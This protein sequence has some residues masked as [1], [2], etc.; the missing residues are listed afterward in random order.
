MTTQHQIAKERKRIPAMDYELLRR[1]GLKHIEDLAHDLWTDYNTH[2]PGITLLEALCY[3]ITELGYRTQFDMKS[4]LAGQQNQ[5]LYTPKEILTVNPVTISDYR[6]LLLD[7]PGVNNAWLRK[8]ERQEIPFYANLAADTLQY[9]PTD[10]EIKLGGL[11]D[12]WLD[13]EN[14]LEYGDLNNGDILIGNPKFRFS[15]LDEVFPETFLLKIELPGLQ[16]TEHP[17]LLWEAPTASTRIAETDGRKRYELELAAHGQT[18]IIPFQVSIP[19]H[20]SIG[21]ITDEHIEVMLSKT[22]FAGQLAEQYMAKLKRAKAILLEAERRLHAHRNL[23]EDFLSVKHI[24]SEEIAFCFDVDAAADA[25]IEQVQAAVFFAIENYLNPPVRFYA[26]REM[27]DQGVSVDE[28]F[29]GVVLSHGFVNTAQLASAQLRETVRSSDIINLLMDIPGVLGI[30]NFV[31]TKYDKQGKPI[32]GSI[33]VRWN[34]QVSSGHKPVI[35]PHA[36]KVLFFKNGIPLLAR[37]DELQDSIRLLRIGRANDKLGSTQGDLPIPQAGARDTLSYWPVQYDLPITYGV[38]KYGLPVHAD[39]KRRGQQKQLRG[40]LLFFEQLL[41]DFFAQ[42]THAP[43]LFS[44]KPITRTYFAQYLEQIEGVSEVLSGELKSIIEDSDTGGSNGW[45]N[46]YEKQADFEKRRNR[47]LDH[48]LARFGESFNEY[49]LLQYRINYEA[50]TEERIESSELIQAKINTLNYYP[51]ISANRARAFNY[52]PRSASLDLDPLALWDTENVAGLKKRTSFLTGIENVT[53]R[54][55]HSIKHV[56]IICEETRVGENILCQHYFE[57][58]T[59]SGTQ[60]RSPATTRK[61]DAEA[62]LVYVLELGADPDNFRLVDQHIRL[63]GE[64]DVLLESVASYDTAE[65]ASPAI[66]E[67]ASELALPAD[68]PVGFHLL[69]HILLRPRDDAFGLME[70]CLT[71][72]ECR[73]DEDP[74]SFRVSVVLPYWPGHFDNM[75][76]RAY[77]EQKIREEAPAHVM[78]KVCW[79]DNNQM[80]TFELAYR[81]WLEALAA[82]HG[83]A[84]QNAAALQTANDALLAILAKLNNKYPKASLHDC[85]ESA[86]DSNVV[87]LGKTVLGTFTSN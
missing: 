29:D 16:D 6:K 52:F 83:N 38:S 43:D 39:D 24:D 80:R 10:L 50:R 35:A 40:Y 34:M 4:F 1:E 81:A 7:I 48:L 45:K 61:S 54:Y 22:G 44:S 75:A 12:V 15:P 73:C 87:T 19:K 74:Y 9:H 64:G 58:T 26:L 84:T 23:C 5:V 69:E 57:L 11:Y 56:E 47:F 66:S 49:A 27:L 68:D 17:W 65:A 25:D 51:D 67:L 30:R 70:V 8:S 32:V 78:V 53:R 85:E 31:M 42:L 60:Y 86:L 46:L 28:I 59:R 63:E 79:I 76:F 71:A 62:Y 2:D 20:P 55:L 37:Y 82:Y 13:L 18:A 41:A 33:G 14:D 3:A 36:S 72:D 77:F 21:R